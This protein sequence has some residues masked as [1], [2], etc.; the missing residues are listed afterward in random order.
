MS[1]Q[2][3]RRTSSN[4]PSAQGANVNGFHQPLETEQIAAVS[5]WTK[6]SLSHANG[7]CVEIA[8]LSGGQVG[9]RHS[10]DVTGPVLRIESSEWKAF[11][12]GI[13]NGEFD[14]YTE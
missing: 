5:P 13:R 4:K 6:S 7:N 11:L 8:N 2:S 3:Q 12:R 1:T 10:K 9:M 14:F